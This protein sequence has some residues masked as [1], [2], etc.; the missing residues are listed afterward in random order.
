MTEA[1]IGMGS[2]IEPEKYTPLALESLRA[3]VD[4]LEVSPFYKNRAI[5]T[6][7]G[8]ADFINGVVKIQTNLTAEQ[9]KYDVLREIEFALGRRHLM[10]KN[11]PRTMDL[12]L[13]LFGREKIEELN[14]PEADLINRPFV[15]LPLLDIS[16]EMIIPGMTSPLK[17][18][19]SDTCLD[20]W[21]SFPQYA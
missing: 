4:V 10:P 2:N 19:V 6:A 14:V 5:G 17:E 16:P 21:S 12:D 8:Q 9:L 7:V 20:L 1:Y 13:I 15:Y 3:Y 11:A 18:L